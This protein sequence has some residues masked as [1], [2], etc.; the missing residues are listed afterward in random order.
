MSLTAA[1]RAAETVEK[2]Y[3]HGGET[4]EPDARS[5]AD[6]LRWLHTLAQELQARGIG[7]TVEQAVTGD[8]AVIDAGPEDPGESDY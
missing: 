1:A 2:V 3:S 6:R 4:K 8:A 7:P 5:F